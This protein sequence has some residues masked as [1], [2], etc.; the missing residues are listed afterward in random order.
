MKLSIVG[1]LYQSAS[2]ISEF[3]NRVAATA[4]QLVDEDY[5]IILVNDGS[6]DNCLD[7]AI[8][9]AKNDPRITVVD[10]S[11]N[12]GHHNAMV[13]GL[14]YAR[15]ELIFLIDVDLEEA[16]EWLLLFSTK[17]LERSA[18]VV[19][20][21]QER[22]KGRWFEQWSGK[23][24]YQL[25]RVLSGVDLPENIMTAR[26]MSSRYVKALLSHHEKEI[27]LGGLMHITGFLQIPLVL[28]KGSKQGTSYTMR[29]RLALL[30]RAVT[31]FSSTPLVFIF[32]AG[33][34]VFFSSLLLGFVVLG[35]WMA[36]SITVAGWVSVMLSI[37]FLGGVTLM[38]LGIVGIYISKVFVEAKARPISIIRDVY[39][40]G[41]DEND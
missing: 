24:F 11:R 33:L 14:S 9:L 8:N 40:R 2:F 13:T 17:M 10:L 41:R 3:Y 32:Y 30:V 6:P 15:G 1:T 37:W 31:S 12:F 38:A 26:L 29:R 21:V 20:G 34:L 35:K 27:F 19:F 36:G 22:R 23:F 5:E 25:F 39:N 4:S 28:T 7:L 18:D 16:P